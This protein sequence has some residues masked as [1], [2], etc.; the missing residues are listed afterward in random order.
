MQLCI[1]GIAM[2]TSKSCLDV[3]LFNYIDIETFMQ[4]DYSCWTLCRE[5]VHFWKQA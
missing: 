4:C 2:N 1:M 3:T 5:Y